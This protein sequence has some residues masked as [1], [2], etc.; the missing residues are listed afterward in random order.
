MPQEGWP[1]GVPPSGVLPQGAPPPGTTPL[2]EP[3][4]PRAPQWYQDRFKGGGLDRPLYAQAGGIAPPEERPE[5]PPGLYPYGEP[6]PGQESIR[7]SELPPGM[8]TPELIE[9]ILRNPGN[10]NVSPNLAADLRRGAPSITSQVTDPN[11]PAMRAMPP[12]AGGG[13]TPNVGV[14]IVGDTARPYQF[15]GPPHKAQT[16]RT[17]RGEKVTEWP[18]WYRTGISRKAKP[19]EL[20]GVGAKPGQLEKQRAADKTEKSLTRKEMERQ[21]KELMDNLLKQLTRPSLKELR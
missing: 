19:G 12:G 5:V 17:K 15:S 21:H 18:E 20:A 11:S 8:M 10:Q 16:E 2:Y 7:P 3:G 4:D 9:R 13:E 6:P 14:G 1:G